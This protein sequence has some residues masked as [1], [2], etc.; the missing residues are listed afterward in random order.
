MTAITRRS[1]W[2]AG[3]KAVILTPSWR[4]EPAGLDEH[5]RAS[6]VGVRGGGALEQYCHP[7]AP[8]CAPPTQIM[9][10]RTQSFVPC[11]E[12][13]FVQNHLSVSQLMCADNSS[14][15]VITKLSPGEESRDQ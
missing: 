1:C 14:G 7:T 5:T 11:D 9:V 2:R 3:G 4:T 6:I 15:S 10:A 13:P 12:F 8:F